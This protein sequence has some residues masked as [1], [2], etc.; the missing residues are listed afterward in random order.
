MKDLENRKRDGTIKRRLI[1]IV[2]TIA[3]LAGFG[4]LLH[5]PPS[6]V[7]VITGATPKAKKAAQAS[8]QLEGTYVLCI[9]TMSDGLTKEGIRDNL[10]ELA[11]E[12]GGAD[13][14]KEKIRFRLYVPEA[15][16]ALVRY[17]RELR[18]RFARAGV[19]VDLTEYGNTMLLSRVISGKYDVFLAAEDLV[20]VTALDHADY[21]VMDSE[22]MR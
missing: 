7:D 10:K 19:T 2:V 12:T 1:L 15:D 18:D 3:F 21:A 16:D 8:A 13:L 11:A 6:M 22:E 17:A 9:N 14:A 5:A 20:D 4:A